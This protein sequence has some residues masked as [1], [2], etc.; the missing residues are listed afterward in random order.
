MGSEYF[1]NKKYAI[2]YAHF[3]TQSFHPVKAITTGEGGSVISNDKK[4]ID[5]IKLMRSHSMIRNSKKS[6]WLY[7]IFSTGQNYRITD[8]QCALGISQLKKLDKFINERRKI[9][10]FYIDKLKDYEVFTLPFEKKNCKHSFH[11]FPLLIEFKKIKNNRQ[12]V[13]KRFLKKGIK[14]QVHY[15]PIHLQPYYKKNFKIN[16]KELE[17]AEEFYRK[18]ISIPIFPDLKKNDLLK[19]INELKLIY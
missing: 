18:E 10:K 7:N 12:Q 17:N 16:R 8:I 9:A 5:K 3:V 13:F 2:K 14:L 11:L 15:I 1:S 6:P 4:I 19:V